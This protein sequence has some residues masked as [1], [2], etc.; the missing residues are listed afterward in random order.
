MKLDLAK[1]YRDSKISLFYLDAK[2]KEIKIG[3]KRT[4]KNGDI[5]FKTKRKIPVGGKILFKLGGKTVG[6]IEVK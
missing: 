2:G 4:N 3:S 5:S 1:T 6:E